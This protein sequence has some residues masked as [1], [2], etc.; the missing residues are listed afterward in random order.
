M[1]A[2]PRFFS[3]PITRPCPGWCMPLLLTHGPTHPLPACHPPQAPLVDVEDE[4]EVFISNERIVSPAP[5]PPLFG[6]VSD[7]AEAASF[8]P[9]TAPSAAPATEPPAPPPPLAPITNPVV[10]LL[11]QDSAAPPPPSPSLA[12]ASA[13]PPPPPP[14]ARLPS[15]G[16][17]GKQSSRRGL[18]GE[19]KGGKTGASGFTFA[20]KSM[21][22]ARLL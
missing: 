21:D 8:G 19:G 9:A 10:A 20:G 11:H 5:A 7:E 3:M 18:T 15:T 2:A 22:R 12:P 16:S 4:D 6:G 17:A 14:P 1:A 13:P